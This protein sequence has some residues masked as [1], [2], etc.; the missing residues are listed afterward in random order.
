M[1]TRCTVYTGCDVTPEGII[2]PRPIN[3][4]RH[5]SPPRSS[6]PQA[7]Q[8]CREHECSHCIE[9][10]P[11]QSRLMHH[12]YIHTRDDAPA[13]IKSGIYWK[14]Q[15]LSAIFWPFVTN[16]WSGT[17]K[18]FMERE[19]STGFLLKYQWIDQWECSV[20]PSRFSRK[21]VLSGF[22]LRLR[23]RPLEFSLHDVSLS[24]LFL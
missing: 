1:Y 4:S 24:M 6:R 12:M 20:R 22:Q 10:L 18:C 2:I 13:G 21:P 9:H 8:P 11:C 3:P 16:S 23:I 14:I 15:E 17:Q 5:P 7:H 19:R